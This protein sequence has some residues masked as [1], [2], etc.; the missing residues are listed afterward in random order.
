MG[1]LREAVIEH[2]A[3]QLADEV[4]HVFLRRS[5]HSFGQLVELILHRHAAA[6]SFFIRHDSHQRFVVVVD[7]I[8]RPLAVV[9]TT[10][11]ICPE[12]FDLR[13]YGINIDV[14]HYDDRLVVRTVPF[15]VVVTQGLIS[16]VID[17]GGI[18]DDVTFG[19]LGT[20]VHLRVHLFPYTA[21]RCATCTPFLEDDAA[22]CIDLF[23]QKEQ[24]AAPVVHH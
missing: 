22:L 9:G 2:V 17:D 13:L 3:S 6:F 11:N 8:D 12:G 4:E 16:E 10:R 15:M 1:E 20:R 7:R 24:T 14:A 19:V 21:T 23:V 5:L 18:A